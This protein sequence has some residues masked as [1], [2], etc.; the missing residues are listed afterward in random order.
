[1]VLKS[2]TGGVADSNDQAAQSLDPLEQPS[3]V[4]CELYKQALECAGP[5]LAK[6]HKRLE[7]ACVALFGKSN[8]NCLL[9]L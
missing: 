2:A 9:M 3:Q 5:A 7:D 4:L 1:M 6:S 8:D